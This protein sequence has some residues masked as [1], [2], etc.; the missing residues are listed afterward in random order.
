M[1][2]IKN[3]RNLIKISKNIIFL[4]LFNYN[5]KLGQIIDLNYHASSNDSKFMTGEVMTVDAGYE[6]NHDLSSKNAEGE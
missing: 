2:I 5:E 4:P 6:M 3:T 1:H